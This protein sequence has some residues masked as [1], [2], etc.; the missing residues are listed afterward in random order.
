LII[1]IGSRNPAKIK[2]IERAFKEVFRDSN[3]IFKAI[4]V[5]TSIPSQPIGLKITLRGAIERALFA[6]REIPDASYGVGV[7]AGLVEVPYTITG[8]MDLEVCA[9]IDQ[10][11]RVTLGFSS[12]FEFP[13]LAVR[14][15]LEGKVG[16]IEEIMERISGIKHIGD[17]MGAIGY[18]TKGVIDRCELTRQCVIA[19]LIPRINE[20]VYSITKWPKAQEVL[21]DYP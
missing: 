2:G 13:P 8:F 18:L 12:A 1:A 21:K 20:E 6:L 16:E 3:I 9:I 10:E 5:E 15:V 7:E 19:A 11:E 4:K 14:S 17:G